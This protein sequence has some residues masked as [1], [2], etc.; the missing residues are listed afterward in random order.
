MKTSRGASAYTNE[1]VRSNRISYYEATRTPITA[2]RIVELS[3]RINLEKAWI[4]VS[5]INQM[6][7]EYRPTG[8]AFALQLTR[9]TEL[10]RAGWTHEEGQWIHEVDFLTRDGKLHLT[11]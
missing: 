4:F 6:R 7:R 8:R 9:A 5:G 11:K 10:P 1:C 3:A 2:A